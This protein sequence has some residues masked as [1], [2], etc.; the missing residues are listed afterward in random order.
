M[1]GET[2]KTRQHVSLGQNKNGRQSEASCKCEGMILRMVSINW[3][4]MLPYL[5]QD[6]EGI[7]RKREFVN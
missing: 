7:G 3:W 5:G 2:Q 6:Y 1:K 4:V